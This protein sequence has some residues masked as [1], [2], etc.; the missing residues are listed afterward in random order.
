VGR[1]PVRH[2]ISGV[3]GA[4]PGRE[5]GTTR[6]RGRGPIVGALSVRVPPVTA[7]AFAGLVAVGLTQAADALT[8]SAM[9]QLGG[10]ELERNPLVALAAARLGIPALF[11]AKAALVVLVVSIAVIIA[12]HWSWLAAMVLTTGMIAGLIGAFSNFLAIA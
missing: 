8:F 12:R 4:G 9:T 11:V 7:F 6:T 2:A 1:I 3:A 10:L 5:S